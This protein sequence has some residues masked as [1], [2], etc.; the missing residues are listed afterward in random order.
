[1]TT[2]KETRRTVA[3]ILC[4][5]LCVVALALGI[6]FTVA[7]FTA[8]DFLKAVAATNQ[9]ENLFASDVLAGYTSAPDNDA[10]NASRKSMVVS[11]AD[12]KASFSF[13][14][15][16]HLKDNKNVVNTNDVKYMLTVEVQGEGLSDLSGY[17]V[18]RDGGTATRIG[19]TFT[20]DDLTLH[21]NVAETDT[22]T[23]TLPDSDLGKA[24]FVI[25]AIAK[26]GP[27]T[28]L[29]GLAAKVIPSIAASVES[30]SVRGELKLAS[31][32]G[33]TNDAYNY[34]ITVTGK[35]ADVTLTWPSEKVEIEPFFEEKYKKES[36]DGSATFRLQDGSAKFHLQPG[37]TTINFYQ[38]NGN[39]VT[40]ADFTC[41]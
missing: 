13:E 4:A 24:S 19:S 25:K 3:Y 11:S 30:S 6:R 9:T 12:G 26:S 27:G 1:M 35:E 38:K 39:T 22:F 8:N 20:I 17:S 31:G 41:K 14:V 18:S 40:N 7:A 5:L 36:G 34:E 2:K 28:N 21:G 15:Y 10:L 29:W 16:N 33:A 32:A 23:I 37:V